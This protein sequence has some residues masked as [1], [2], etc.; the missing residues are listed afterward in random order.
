MP[1]TSTD[2]PLVYSALLRDP[3]WQRLRLK[4]MEAAGWQCEYCGAFT[5]PLNIHHP[6]YR[7][8]AKPWQYALRELTCLCDECHDAQHPD[9]AINKPP[10]LI[11]ALAIIANKPDPVYCDTCGAPVTNDQGYG[12]DGKGRK[13]FCESCALDMEGKP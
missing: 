12:T 8:G 4:K 3:R 10:E 1:P 6:N 9:K 5:K 13:F 2:P 7:R 11:A